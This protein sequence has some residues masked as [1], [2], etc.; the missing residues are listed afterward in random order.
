MTVDPA[1]A[2]FRVRDADQQTPREPV[3]FFFFIR[4]PSAATIDLA[5]GSDFAQ[6]QVNAFFVGNRQNGL[7]MTSREEFFIKLQN[8]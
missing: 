2:L 8:F 5:A 6:K 7:N 1:G 3:F 4:S